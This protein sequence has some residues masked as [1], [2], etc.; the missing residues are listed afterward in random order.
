MTQL[1]VKFPAQGTK[2]MLT[3][4]E[5]ILD[6]VDRARKKAQSHEFPA[7]HGNVAEAAFRKWLS[8]FLP[9]RYGVT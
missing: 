9:K 3:S 8:E 6:A 1:K 7:Y 2:Q 5:E 4:R